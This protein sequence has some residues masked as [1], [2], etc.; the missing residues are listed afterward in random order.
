MNDET[1]GKSDRKVGIIAKLMAGR[2]GGRE[3][4]NKKENG[5]EYP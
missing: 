3:T 1:G 2:E 4:K 5:K